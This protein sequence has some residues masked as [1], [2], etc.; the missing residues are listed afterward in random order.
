MRAYVVIELKSGKFKPEYAGQL[1]FYLTAIDRQLK[2]SEDNPTVGILLC[3]SKNKVVAQYAVDGMVK[4][5][6]ISEYELS[7]ALSQRL[8]R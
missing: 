1:N 4:P 8:S 3:E 7:K 5:M 2:V 6:G